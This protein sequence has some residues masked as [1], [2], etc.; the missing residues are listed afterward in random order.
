LG[1]EQITAKLAGRQYIYQ[2]QFAVR[3]QRRRRQLVPH[4]EPPADG[5]ARPDL[6]APFIE[7]HQ[8]RS[9]YGVAYRHDDLAPAVADQI[10]PDGG[11]PFDNFRGASMSE[12]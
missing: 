10:G 8:L 2:L 9:P 6:F 7:D 1:T 4:A 5:S 11:D 12:K 3:P